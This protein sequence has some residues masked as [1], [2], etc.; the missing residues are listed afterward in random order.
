L[1]ND[2]MWWVP[3]GLILYRTLEQ[4]LAED[5]PVLPA[6]EALAQVHTAAGPTLTELSRGA[7]LLVV[8]FRH[9]G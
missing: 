6:N 1:T 3:F 8:F 5:A 4:S 9:F 2:L 7:P